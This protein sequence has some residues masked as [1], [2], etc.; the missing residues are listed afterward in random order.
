MQWPTLKSVTEVSQVLGLG[1][2]Y[3]R[4]IK[5]YTTLFNPMTNL[6]RKGTDFE[7]T[8]SFQNALEK[9]KAALVGPEVELN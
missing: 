4:F 5:D 9:L 2:Y 3:R 1:S 7:W 8:D 6:L